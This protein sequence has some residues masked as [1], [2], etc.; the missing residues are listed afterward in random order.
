MYYR[1]VL[2]VVTLMVSGAI[3]LL[4]IAYGMYKATETNE[5]QVSL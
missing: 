3:V 2:Y 5:Y 4:S 1:T